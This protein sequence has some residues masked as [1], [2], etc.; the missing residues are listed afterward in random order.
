MTEQINVSVRKHVIAD[1]LP[2]FISF[3]SKDRKNNKKNPKYRKITKHDIDKRDVIYR[4]AS[5]KLFDNQSNTSY[6]E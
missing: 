5:K 1:H 4:T 3:S 6:T 2:I